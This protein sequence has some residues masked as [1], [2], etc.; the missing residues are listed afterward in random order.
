MAEVIAGLETGDEGYQE[1]DAALHITHI[2]GFDRAVHVAQGEGEAGGR[3]TAAGAV[4][5]VGIGAGGA[6]CG[7]A[8]QGDFLLVGY[9]F[10]AGVDIGVADRAEAEAGAGT[11]ADIAIAG[12]IK[13]G[14][15]GGVGDIEADGGIGLNP[16]GK[17]ASA[18]AADFFLHG[19]GKDDVPGGFDALGGEGSGGFGQDE[20][21]EAVIECAADETVAMAEEEGAIAID[22]DAADMQAEGFHF[23]AGIAAEVDVELVELGG[24]LIG[25]AASQVDGGVAGDADDLAVGSQEADA[26]APGNGDIAAADA[27]DAG[28]A[29]VIDVADGEADFI[30][31]GIEH[32]GG[33]LFPCGAQQSPGG[34]IGIAL[35]FVGVGFDVA[36]PEALGLHFQP[37][38]GGR[39]EVFAQEISSL[40]VHGCVC[41][42][43]Q[44]R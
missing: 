5:L 21:A 22:A 3:Y 30:G 7:F 12:F 29:V 36:G 28:E 26:A 32:E 39:L 42:W 27:F 37:R 6:A 16:E 38:R 41:V 24:F 18:D 25:G 15:V 4:D 40:F 34:T 14:G 10:Q 13:A 19:V 35:H 44:A 31:M 43:G 23:F 33:G 2:G 11:Q 20:A 8:L 9:E 1:V 17:H